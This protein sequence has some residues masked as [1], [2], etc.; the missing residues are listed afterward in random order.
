MSYEVFTFG[1]QSTDE[2]KIYFFVRMTTRKFG[3][4]EYGVHDERFYTSSDMADIPIKFL[5]FVNR[6]IRNVL[7]CILFTDKI[8]NVGQKTGNAFVT[9]EQFRDILNMTGY[10]VSFQLEVKEVQIVFVKSAGKISISFIA[11]HENMSAANRC[12]ENFRPI[13]RNI[14]MRFYYNFAIL[15]IV[16]P[17]TV[18]HEFNKQFL[19]LPLKFVRRLQEELP[20]SACGYILVEGRNCTNSFLCAGVTDK[21]FPT[22]FFHEACLSRRKHLRSAYC[23]NF[24]GEYYKNFSLFH[25][26]FTFNVWQ[27]IRRFAERSTPRLYEFGRRRPRNSNRVRLK[28]LF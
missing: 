11:R 15:V 16:Q 28:N 13:S 10:F 12:G 6:K 17:Q 23:Q 1:N 5:N 14:K 22:F 19:F 8:R 18:N 2:H 27:Y 21:N 4:P 9:V 26:F 20:P 24:V 3:N 7:N 25:L